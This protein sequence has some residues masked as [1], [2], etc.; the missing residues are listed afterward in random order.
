[1]LHAECRDQNALSPNKI[2]TRKINRP[3]YSNQQNCDLAICH[4]QNHLQLNTAIP[5]TI[6]NA[7]FR[8]WDGIWNKAQYEVNDSSFISIATQ[9]QVP[10]QAPEGRAFKPVLAA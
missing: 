1:M 7:G 4:E 2:H 8:A 5:V 6:Q 10:S 9:Y 3:Q